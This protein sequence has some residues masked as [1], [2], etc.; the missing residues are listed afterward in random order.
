[1]AAGFGDS[2]FND[3]VDRVAEV[4]EHVFLVSAEETDRCVRLVRLR[5][6]RS[7]VDGGRQGAGHQRGQVPHEVVL[8]EQKLFLRDRVGFVEQDAD[9]FELVVSL[10]G[11]HIF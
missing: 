9:L 7:G 2:V 3:V 1:M 11:V 5:P 8:D 6:E 4:F 10:D